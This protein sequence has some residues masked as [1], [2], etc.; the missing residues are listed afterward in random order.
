MGQRAPE[1]SRQ[2]IEVINSNKTSGTKEHYCSQFRQWV[3]FCLDFE[4]NPLQFP[5]STEVIMFWIQDRFNARG[6]IKSFRQW[7]GML[8]WISQLADA[9]MLWKSSPQFKLFRDSLYKQHEE[10]VDH[11]LPFTLKH[12]HKYTNSLWYPPYPSYP[13]QISYDNLIRVCLANLY[14]FTMSRQCEILMSPS[15]N[16]RMR[17]IRI[18]QYQRYTDLENKIPLIELS[19]SN[20]KNAA[21]RKIQKKI[22]ISSTSCYHSKQK[23]NG[24]EC[25]CRKCNPYN[26]LLL[27]NKQRYHLCQKLIKLQKSVKSVKARKKLKKRIDSLSFKPDNHL[28]VWS[29]GKPVTT[30]DLSKISK[31]IVNANKIVDGRH[32]TSYSLRIGGTTLASQTGIDH[33]KILKYVGWSNSRLADCA[34][35]YMRYSPSQLSTIPYEM[36]H[37]VQNKYRKSMDNKIYDPWSERTNFKFYK[38]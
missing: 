6:N 23:P 33:P 8:H 21:S 15:D 18:N 29:N 12:I 10:G 34:Q 25:E 16:L 24:E 5:L 32:Y 31:D 36:I 30:S 9:P 22:Y 11:R 35:R 1:L 17:G 28:F 27:L 7:T 14:F 20:Y 26:L 13:F 4:L 19:I 3:R 37:G 2:I 38:Y